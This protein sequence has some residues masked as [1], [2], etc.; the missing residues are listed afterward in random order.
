[1]DASIPST[2]QIESELHEVEK[3]KYRTGTIQGLLLYCGIFS[4]I[5][6][7][8]MVIF[9]PLLYAGYSSFSQTV[10]ELSA[11]GA[12]TRML[13]N[14]LSIFFILLLTAFGCGILLS[15][16][17]K[18]TLRIAGIVLTLYGIVSIFWP[19]MH[20]REVLAAGGKTITDT[21]HIAFTMVTGFLMMLA[22]G[23]GAAA[24][25]NWFSLYSIVSILIIFFFGALTGMSAPK[26]EANL[27]TPWMG[28]WQRINIYAT[29]LWLMWLAI[30]LLKRQK[31]AMSLTQAKPARFL[32]IKSKQK[33]YG[34]R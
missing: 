12:P 29:M 3:A 32:R 6:Y 13:W 25:R 15:T 22:M 5:L 8:S 10:S 19:P 17:E 20:Q 14:I 9:V 34:D 27:P 28:V 16:G 23:F 33:S 24:F 18:R 26:L 30:V 2:R 4:S 31:E 1:M 21:M 11:I 7:T